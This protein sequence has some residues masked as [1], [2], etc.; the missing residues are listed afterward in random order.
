MIEIFV[1]SELS[2]LGAGDEFS[3]HALR[4]AV[5]LRFGLLLS[6]KQARNALYR[7]RCKTGFLMHLGR[8]Y[9]AIV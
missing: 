9:Y 6:Y 5:Y 7:L 4:I 1:E 3:I 8:G 2:S